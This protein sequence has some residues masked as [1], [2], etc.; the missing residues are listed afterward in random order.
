MVA[1]HGPNPTELDWKRSMRIAQY[2]IATAHIGLTIGG[3][4]GVQLVCSVDSSYATHADM[5]SH[6]MWS[7][8][9]GGSGTVLARTKKQSIMSDSSTL[10]ELIG[11][12]LALRD[13]MWARKFLREIGF[14][15]KHPTTLF[16]DNKS[17][18]KIIA[19]PTDSGKTR[20]IDIRY[21]MIREQ[22]KQGHIRCEYLCTEHMIADIG[23]KAL[24]TGP[25]LYLRNFLLGSQTLAEFA[26]TY[27]RYRP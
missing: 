10:S 2:L 19:N 9:L 24:S 22:V 23:T 25:F 12:H 7:L 14:R 11:A 5:K 20:H 3:T 8:H 21:N 17:T 4:H 13:I 18:L 16:I 27:S 15:Q 1:R 6:S 26:S